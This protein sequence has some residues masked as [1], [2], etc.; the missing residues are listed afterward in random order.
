M[1]NFFSSNSCTLLVSLLKP[2]G[3]I[4][5]CTRTVQN[6]FGISQQELIQKSI[7]VLIPDAIAAVHDSI[8]EQFIKEGN[9]DIVKSGSR[10]LFGK[11]PE[12]FIFPLETTLRLANLQNEFGISCFMKM[13]DGGNEYILIDD[14]LTAI[15]RK[16]RIVNMSKGLY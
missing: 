9:T 7:N 14:K 3:I 8:I 16:N 5:K 1:L 11:S 12:N 13:T 10:I 15:G 2:I 6:V 4:K